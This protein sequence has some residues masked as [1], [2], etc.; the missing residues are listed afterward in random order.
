MGFVCP[1]CGYPDLEKDP[2]YV[3]SFE[4]CPSCGFQFRVTDDDKGFTYAQWRKLWID[5]GMIWDEG[6]SPP[7][8]A[9]NP[10]KQLKNLA[11]E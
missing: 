9:W 2:H 10:I 1:A 3:G 6:R 7:P 4:I 11:L 5:G 8:K